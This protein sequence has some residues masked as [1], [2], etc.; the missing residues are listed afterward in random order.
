LGEYEHVRSNP[1]WFALAPGHAF[2]EGTIVQR[3]DRFEVVEKHG[4][5]AEIAVD[6]DPR[7]DDVDRA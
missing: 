2:A 1:H 3:T 7:R 6:T 4:R 5:A